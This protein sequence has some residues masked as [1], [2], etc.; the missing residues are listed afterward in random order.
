MKYHA[1]FVLILSLFF[2]TCTSTQTD[3]TGIWQGELAVSPNEKLT[4]QFILSLQANG[5][6]TAVVNSLD[7]GD[8][9]NVSATA[10]KFDEGKLTIEVDGLDGSYSGTVDRKIITGEWK[11]PASALPLVLNWYE[12]PDVST[13]RPLVGEWIGKF[14]PPGASELTTV[15]RFEISKNDIFEAFLDIPGQNT[16]GLEVSKVVLEG[17]KLSFR[18]PAAQVDYIGRLSGDNIDGTF[19]QGGTEFE[20]DLSKRK[21][22]SPATKG[23]R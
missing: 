9:R 22:E 1:K 23:A 15:F 13:L 21:Y 18:I 17:D 19:N 2:C 20:L 11:E 5:S 8:I 16:K 6:Y 4:I 12:K 7:T 10:V 14:T 3:L